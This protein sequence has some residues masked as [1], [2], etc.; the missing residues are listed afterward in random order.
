M[1]PVEAPTI[2]YR[3]DKTFISYG[4]REVGDNGQPTDGSRIIYDPVNG[5]SGRFQVFAP[6]RQGLPTVLIGI[7]RNMA[8]SMG[9]V[10]D[11]HTN[12]TYYA[13]LEQQAAQLNQRK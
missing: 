3:P 7:P 10:Q 2:G 12:E 9:R 13:W 8:I 1:A 11:T 5:N 4:S 6:Q